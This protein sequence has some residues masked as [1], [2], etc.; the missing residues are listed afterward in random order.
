MA[1]LY[2]KV[3]KITSDSD[4]RIIEHAFEMLEQVELTDKNR[5]LIAQKY[6]SLM[7]DDEDCPFP[8]EDTN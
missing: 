2:N 6:I 1:N 8:S 5:Q 7:G 4:L 3:E